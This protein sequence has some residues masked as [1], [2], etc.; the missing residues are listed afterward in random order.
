MNLQ[1]PNVTLS[2][3]LSF[4]KKEKYKCK[5]EYGKGNYT[6]FIHTLN[7]DTIYFY[8]LPYLLYKCSS[9]D[10]CYKFIDKIA[11]G[12]FNAIG[13]FMFETNITETD[14][15]SFYGGFVPNG[16]VVVNHFLLEEA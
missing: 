12:T 3:L 7:N 11:F 4:L 1:D 6:V 16:N 15:Y 2:N 10:A 9:I 5:K 14:E 8:D 13:V